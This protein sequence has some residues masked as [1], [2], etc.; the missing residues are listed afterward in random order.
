M[1]PFI[2]DEILNDHDPKLEETKSV[3]KLVNLMSMGA[4]KSITDN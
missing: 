2:R 4:L 1:S 3:Q